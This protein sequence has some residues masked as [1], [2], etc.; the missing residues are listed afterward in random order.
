MSKL[1]K[2][3]V[4]Y[5]KE[6]NNIWRCSQCST[7]KK[8]PNRLE[9]PIRP[10]NVDLLEIIEILFQLKDNFQA[11]KEDTPSNSNNLNIKFNV[12][13]KLITENNILKTHIISLENETEII[14][15][16]QIANDI[17]ID[18][19]AENRSNLRTA[20]YK[21]I[22]GDLNID[23]LKKS[24]IKDECLIIMAQFGYYAVIKYITRTAYN[25]CIDHIFIK[26]KSFLNIQPIIIQSNITDHYPFMIRISN[27]ILNNCMNKPNPLKILKT[28]KLKL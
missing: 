5:L 15:W 4:S 11:F 13:D 12:I 1:S 7:A 10:G 16:R 22:L 26:T 25:T 2:E 8:S 6:A 9:N 20:E 18:G 19:I 28:D 24:K 23:I 21:I 3:D 17:I 14:E 27:I